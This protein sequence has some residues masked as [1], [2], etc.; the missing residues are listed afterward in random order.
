MQNTKIVWS[1]E[2]KK[3]K[4]YCPEKIGSYPYQ[5]L[6]IIYTK[7][8]SKD[9]LEFLETHQKHKEQLDTGSYKPIIIDVSHKVQARV[10]QNEKTKPLENGESL[11]F[12]P[13][14]SSD[15]IQIT[16]DEWNGLFIK[17]ELV[18]LN[19]G[20]VILSIEQ[21]EKNKVKTKVLQGKE[22]GAGMELTVPA[23]ATP[24]SIFDLAFINIKD[25]LDYS[26][27]YVILPGLHSEREIAIIQKK[28]SAQKKNPPS[29][30]LKVDSKEV[31]HNLKDILP[32]VSGV[33]VSRRGLALRTDPVTV[34][35]LSKEIIHEANKQ[36]KIVLVSSE[37]LFSMRHSPTP[38][39]AEVSDIANA[40]VDGTDAVVLSKE[41]AHGHNT[42]RALR[43]AEK[44]IEEAESP[45]N[46]KS[47]WVKDK[48]QVSDQLANLAYYAY[49]TAQRV[50]AKTLVCLTKEGNT[51]R[52]L[53]SYRPNIPIIALTFNERTKARISLIR[54]VRSIVLQG[55]PVLDKVL[56]TVTELLKKS[57]QLKAKD[58]F[59]FVTLSLSPISGEASNLFT[60]QEIT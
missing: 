19:N 3:L 27:D 43:V 1:L 37:M 14:G 49:L 8:D 50:Q 2:G 46:R 47:N 17:D 4:D 29:L 25:F 16:T 42:L 60:V 34:P 31:Y 41:I 24:A 21:V 39:R 48:I 12:V 23:S 9:I 40:V 30:L 52:Q 53:A 35:L 59:V 7:E 22:I 20:N 58:L 5:A 44:I 6:R 18:Y 55:E 54:G 33:V 38:T 36:A 10:S 15:G 28:L 26:I 45:T 13:E 57:G 51:A 32:L 56:P 11:Y